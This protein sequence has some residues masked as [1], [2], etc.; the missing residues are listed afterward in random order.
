MNENGVQGELPIGHC[1]NQYPSPT[2]NAPPSG[3]GYRAHDSQDIVAVDPN[4]V[5]AISYTSG[6]N[7]VPV[8]LFRRW[9]GYSETVVPRNE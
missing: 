9:S 4:G 5:N 8:I 2:F 1:F 7:S 6:S 3:L